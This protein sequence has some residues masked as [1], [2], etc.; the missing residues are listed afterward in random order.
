MR[1]KEE[2]FDSES[3]IKSAAPVLTDQLVSLKT[4]EKYLSLLVITALVGSLKAENTPLAVNNFD[5]DKLNKTVLNLINNS[6][7]FANNIFTVKE[8]FD[9]F[10]T[11]VVNAYFKGYLSIGYL[12]MLLNFGCAVNPF[13]PADVAKKVLEIV[14]QRFNGNIP[15]TGIPDYLDGFYRIDMTRSF[16]IN[17]ETDTAAAIKTIKTNALGHTDYYSIIYSGIIQFSYFQTLNSLKT[18]QITKDQAL[19]NMIELANNITSTLPPRGRNPSTY[20]QAVVD[21]YTANNYATTAGFGAFLCVGMP[22]LP[23]ITGGQ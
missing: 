13:D 16:G 3:S 11:F 5:A 21:Y 1:N 9:V 14:L 18:L 19:Q 7:P 12:Q 23:E 22:Y 20:A 17:N 10:N 6:P 4:M 15:Y 8:V 2:L